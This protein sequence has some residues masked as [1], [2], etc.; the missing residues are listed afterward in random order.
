VRRIRTRAVGPRSNGTIDAI[1]APYL[2]GRTP[3]GETAA[4]PAHRPSST[5]VARTRTSQLASA[6]PR[7]LIHQLSRGPRTRCQRRVP[8]TT[9]ARRITLFAH[10]EQK[11]WR[12]TR[13]DFTYRFQREHVAPGVRAAFISRGTYSNV[14][15]RS[16]TP[17]AAGVR[18]PV[19]RLQRR[20]GGLEPPGMI[21]LQAQ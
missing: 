1:R 18:Q 15:E 17:R 10:L 9:Q 13:G 4:V 14:R 21:Q 2:S 11:R 6:F 19:Q 16:L 3:G 12:C 20:H 8:D 7:R 5:V